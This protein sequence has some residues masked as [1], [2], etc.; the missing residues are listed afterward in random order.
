[1]TFFSYPDWVCTTYQRPG[2]SN[3]SSYGHF[4][5]DRFGVDAF[6]GCGLVV[7]G[8]GLVAGVGLAGLGRVGVGFD[9]GVGVGFGFE[10]VGV[11]DRQHRV[12][13]DGVACGGFAVDVGQHV[14]V[15]LGQ[16]VGD[17]VGLGIDRRFGVDGEFV[18]G[19]LGRNAVRV[20]GTQLSES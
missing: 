2:R 11:A 4:F 14:G 5:F 13:G 6:G 3:G 20:G 9:F 19:S 7:F 17:G 12:G 16:Q 8:G 15:A 1:M 10:H 18:G